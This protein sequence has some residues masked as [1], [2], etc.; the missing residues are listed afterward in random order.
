MKRVICLFCAL[1][2]LLSAGCGGEKPGP[3]TPSPLPVT[4]ERIYPA[5]GRLR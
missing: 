3:A 1:L 5:S 2:F 4:A